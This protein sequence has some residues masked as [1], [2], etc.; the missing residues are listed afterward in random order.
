PHRSQSQPQLTHQK[1]TDSL[2]QDIQ[3]M[4]KGLHDLDVNRLQI[5]KSQLK[6]VLK[7]V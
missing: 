4:T 5:V 2:V 7:E 6:Y 3:N 1:T